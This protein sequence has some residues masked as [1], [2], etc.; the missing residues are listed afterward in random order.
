MKIVSIFSYR[1]NVGK[2]VLASSLAIKL[3]ERG[4]NVGVLDFDLLTPGGLAML[5]NYVDID[6]G[7]VDMLLDNVPLSSIMIDISLNNGGNKLYL[8]PAVLD[9]QKI[10]RIL[11]EGCPFRKLKEMFNALE[12]E[13]DILIVDTHAGFVED[14]ITMLTLSNLVVLILRYDFQDF[15]GTRIAASILRKMGMPLLGIVNMVPKNYKVNEL[16]DY[17]KGKIGVKPAVAIP[18]Y[19][20]LLEFMIG[21]PIQNFINQHEKF[22][23][24]IEKLASIV[25]VNLHNG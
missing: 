17:I 24:D 12:K 5:F 19:E 18:F 3:Y 15:I 6:V 16:L 4:Y 22:A 14:T 23:K 8:I 10:I 2:T 7:V 13:V 21:E 25:E 20:E 11:R 1:G 9:I